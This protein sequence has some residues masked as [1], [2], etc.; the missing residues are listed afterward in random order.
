MKEIY[1][2]NQESIKNVFQNKQYQEID[3]LGSTKTYQIIEK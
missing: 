1:R 3:M 2:E